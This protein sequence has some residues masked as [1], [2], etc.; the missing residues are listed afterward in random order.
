MNGGKTA[1][2]SGSELVAKAAEIEHSAIDQA[3]ATIPPNLVP[4]QTLLDDLCAAPEVASRT[5]IRFALSRIS[6]AKAYGLLEPLVDV[7]LRL[8]HGADHTARLFR[9]SGRWQQLGD[10]YVDNSKRYAQSLSWPLYH[11]GMMFPTIST[12][13]AALVTYW[14]DSLG[15]GTLPMIMVP[16][17]VQRLASWNANQGRAAI[18]AAATQPAYRHPF[19]LRAL[20]IGGRACGLNPTQARQILMQLPETEIILAYLEA[21]AMKAPKVSVAVG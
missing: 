5:S 16:L 4:L 7:A 18:Q 8:P 1:V 2:Y 14:T 20:A 19:A 9:E 10:W 15:S 13:P 17:A 3:L 6:K 12:P 21:N 11:L